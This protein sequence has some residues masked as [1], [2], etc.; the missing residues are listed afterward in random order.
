MSKSTK[1][2]KEDTPQEF[3]YVMGES[4]CAPT[5]ENNILPSPILLTTGEAHFTNEEL[6]SFNSTQIYVRLE[7]VG[8]LQ[9]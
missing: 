7:D 6:Q 9:D 1:T 5:L 2:S 8:E 3:E 4:G